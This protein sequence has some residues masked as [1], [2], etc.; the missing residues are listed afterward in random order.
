MPIFTNCFCWKS[1]EIID[2]ANDAFCK[3]QHSAQARVD[4][5]VAKFIFDQR[6]FLVKPRKM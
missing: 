6:L 4:E 3:A 1:G 5:I 2:G